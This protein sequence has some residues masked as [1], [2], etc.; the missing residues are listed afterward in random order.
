[1]GGRFPTGLRAVQSSAILVSCADWSRRTRPGRARSPLAVGASHRATASAVESRRGRRGC[2][3][4]SMV[5]SQSRARQ[6]VWLAAEAGPVFTWT[7]CRPVA[8]AA[9]LAAGQTGI[10]VV[11]RFTRPV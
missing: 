8:A 10:L 4:R 6:N 2:R 9:H 1:M 3:S 5:A 11:T 7:T